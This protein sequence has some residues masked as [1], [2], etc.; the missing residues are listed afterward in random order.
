[1]ISHIPTVK[2]GLLKK[3]SNSRAKSSR[4]S[5]NAVVIKGHEGKIPGFVL[6]GLVYAPGCALL[7]TFH[8][9]DAKKNPSGR[10]GYPENYWNSFFVS[11]KCGKRRG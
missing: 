9:Y 2:Q 11:T 10:T 6:C 1:M 4:Q 5:L 7:V 3:D 8:V